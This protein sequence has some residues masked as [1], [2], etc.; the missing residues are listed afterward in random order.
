MTIEQQ[1][2]FAASSVTVI[3]A[4]S[5]ICSFKIGAHSQSHRAQSGSVDGRR[6][7]S[8]N[9][10]LVSVLLTLLTRQSRYALPSKFLPN[11][12]LTHSFFVTGQTDVRERGRLSE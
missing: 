11:C 10:F 8:Q 4:L 6:K 7:M 3:S 12:G 5:S 9:G 1:S 2:R